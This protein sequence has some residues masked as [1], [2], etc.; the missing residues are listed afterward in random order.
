[1]IPLQLDK[2]RLD[3]L[4]KDVIEEQSLIADEKKLNLSLQ[5]PENLDEMQ[6]DR[7]QLTRLFTNLISNAV[8]YTP[9]GGT[10]EVTLQQKAQVAQIQVKDT[11]MGI[12]AEA[13]PQVFDRFYRVDPARSGGKAK[14]ETGLGLAIAKVI[15]ESHQGQIQVESVL[16]QGTTF[17]VSL[18]CARPDLA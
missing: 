9:A 5:L 3:E 7:N 14:A 13:L 1:M 8:Q 15:A 17:T 18:P 12:P 16:K 11:G 4:L 2:V 6:G 10:I